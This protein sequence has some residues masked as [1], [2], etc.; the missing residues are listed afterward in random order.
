MFVS[1]CLLPEGFDAEWSAMN[2]S[3]RAATLDVQP[4][5]RRI[6]ALD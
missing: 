4:A 1:V 5:L 2:R 6:V 3:F